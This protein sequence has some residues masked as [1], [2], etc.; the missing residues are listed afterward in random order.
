[1]AVVDAHTMCSENATYQGYQQSVV[2]SAP[3]PVLG[4]GLTDQSQPNLFPKVIRM[5]GLARLSRQNG[6]SLSCQYEV[7]PRVVVPRQPNTLPSSPTHCSP[8]LVRSLTV[9]PKLR[10]ISAIQTHL[11]NNL[12]ASSCSN[13]STCN[14]EYFSFVHSPRWSPETRR[15]SI[16]AGRLTKSPLK[17]SQP[18]VQD[19]NM[20]ASYFSNSSPESSPPKHLARESP[21]TPKSNDR[22][23]LDDHDH[24]HSPRT[25]HSSNSNTTCHS[26][27]SDEDQPMARK[28]NR[29]GSLL[30]LER[31]E[32]I[33]RSTCRR[34]LS[35]DFEKDL[36]FKP[37]INQNSVKIAARIMRQNVPLEVRLFERKKKEVPG[38][39]YSFCPKIN[40]HSIKLIQDKA[41]RM[42]QVL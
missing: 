14:L 20:D 21:E 19:G 25:D 9:T 11:Q 18:E 24:D 34:N 6:R 38:I 37:T 35:K 40:A 8:I 23:S 32:Q 10:S 30:S 13:S 36:T 42:H 29:A 28:T 12:S 16:D 27:G 2:N 5:K 26:S 17:S 15:K 7:K 41:S 4:Q 31:K 39:S 3:G 33:G 22:C 1:M